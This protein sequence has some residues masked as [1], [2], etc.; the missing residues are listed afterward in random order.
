MVLSFV[1][2]IYCRI[3]NLNYKLMYVVL[4]SQRDYISYFS[5]KFLLQ[6]SIKHSLTLTLHGN[7][8]YKYTCYDFDF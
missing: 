8:I 2:I 5:G 7:F 1:R 4:G 3:R 6:T